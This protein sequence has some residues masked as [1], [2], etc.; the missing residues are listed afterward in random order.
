MSYI[1]WI[2]VESSLGSSAAHSLFVESNYFMAILSTRRISSIDGEE[3]RLISGVR[4]RF[5]SLESL[6]VTRLLST[7]R[8][9]VIRVGD[10]DSLRF[11][12]GRASCE[13]LDESFEEQ[14]LRFT[15]FKL[16]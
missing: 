4:E 12:S 14:C 13:F 15:P 2:V 9:S 10:V 6:F 8:R 1:C 11:W 7:V 5:R 3:V 16:L